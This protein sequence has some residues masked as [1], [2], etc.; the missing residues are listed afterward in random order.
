MVTIGLGVMLLNATLNNSSGFF[1]G[2]IPRISP[3]LQ[4]VTDKR[5]T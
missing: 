5:F 3:D 2:G 1:G 4:Q